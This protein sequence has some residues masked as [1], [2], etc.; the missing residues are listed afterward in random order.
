[1]KWYF[2]LFSEVRPGIDSIDHNKYLIYPPTPIVFCKLSNYSQI[3]EVS[4][5]K[6]DPC[7]KPQSNPVWLVPS[8]G[9]TCPIVWMSRSTLFNQ[10]TRLLIAF[11]A[12]RQEDLLPQCHQTT[13]VFA[14]ELNSFCTFQDHL[15][16][17]FSRHYLHIQVCGVLPDLESLPSGLFYRQGNF[18]SFL[19]VP[20]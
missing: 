18:S 20:L 8:Q 4:H 3:V 15:Y 13:Q 14:T 9:G 16:S 19:A 10:F 17:F 12:P 7:P 5:S 11:E 6:D 1:M 2:G